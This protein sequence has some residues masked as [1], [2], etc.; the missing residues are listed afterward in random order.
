MTAEPHGRSLDELRREAARCTGC[1]LHERATQTVF[2]EGPPQAEVMLVGEQPGDREDREGLPFVGPAGR[3]LDQALVDAGID[4]AT[5]YVTN[6]VKHFK[7][8]ERGKRRIHATPL[9]GEID[10]CKPWLVAEIRAVSPRLV[11][12]LGAT[13]ARSVLGPGWKVTQRRG[14]VVELGE[15]RLGTATVHPSS[16]VR[17]QDPEQRAVE[18]HR[19]A[20]DLA[21][22]WT[23]LR[24]A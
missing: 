6:A 11:V 24:G 3:V 19:F 18:R 12:A 15:G 14:E 8:V 4:R 23:R 20:E 10:A 17:I 21:A 16:I 22:A 13:A 9:A 2:G 7:W 1:H 5:V